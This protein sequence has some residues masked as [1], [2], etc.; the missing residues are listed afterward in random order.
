MLGV[1]KN[2][3]R[4]TARCAV[5]LPLLASGCGQG[6]AMP[7]DQVARTSLEAALNAWRDGA[8]PGTI[9]GAQPAVQAVDTTWAKG[10]RLKSYE[11][12]REESSATEKR[13]T[14][15]LLLSEPA[16]SLEAQYDVIGQGP[17]W[18]YRH[19]D[20]VRNMNMEDN[21]QETQHPQSKTSRR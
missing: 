10:Q 1:A 6:G 11:I 19:E 5:L 2:L 3:Q 9:A 16:G 20:Y 14:V 8:K 13:F 7:T 18:V 12:V 17:V 15:Q 21:P 4:L